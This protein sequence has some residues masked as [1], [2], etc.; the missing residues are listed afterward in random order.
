MDRA[1]RLY[2]LASLLHDSDLSVCAE[3]V[4]GLGLPTTA[5]GLLA[6][7]RRTCVDPDGPRLQPVE[8][9]YK[10]WTTAP[11]A[12]LPIARQKGWLG[13][14]AAAHLA[15]LYGALGLEVP[16]GL[17]HAPDHLALE[18]TYYGLMLEHG[19]PEMQATFR[20]QHLDWLGDLQERARELDVPA[21]YR[22]ILRL[23]AE[24]VAA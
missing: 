9:L 19:T 2:L 4:A 16:P 12:A 11:D 21:V 8:S 5:E 10:P 7:Y 14:D 18:L 3:A 22:H 20:S 6:A 17:S 15:T 23:C 1:E 24:A 13:G